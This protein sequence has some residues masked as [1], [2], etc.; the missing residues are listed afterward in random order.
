MDTPRSRVASHADALRARHA[1]LPHERLLNGPVISIC[2]RLAFVLKESICC[3]LHVDTFVV[4]HVVMHCLGS[5]L[6]Q[7][8]GFRGTIYGKTYCLYIVTPGLAVSFERK[9]E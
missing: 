4:Y 2:W 1:F 8:I 6:L 7:D 3:Y 9:K 5:F